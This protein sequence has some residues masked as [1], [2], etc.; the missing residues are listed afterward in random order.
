M[1]TVLAGALCV[2]AVPVV[3]VGTLKQHWTPLL[4]P[5]RDG[6]ALDFSP[7]ELST[8][9]II[10]LM[11]V[12]A[13]RAAM[14]Q[15]G[16]QPALAAELTGAKSQTR[17]AQAS[18]TAV[19][20]PTYTLSMPLTLLSTD[21]KK[22][23]DALEGRSKSLATS[24]GT[25]DLKI[26]AASILANP[27]HLSLFLSAVS[28]PAFL[29]LLA[30]RDCPVQPLGSVNVR[31]RFELLDQARA[32]QIIDGVGNS[33]SDGF[34]T[35][36]Q[37]RFQPTTR[38]AKR[39]IEIDIVVSIVS[40]DNCDTPVPHEIF[41]QTFTVLEFVKWPEHVVTSLIPSVRAS[42]QP[43][44]SMGAIKKVENDSTRQDALSSKIEMMSNDPGLWAA[45]CLDYNPIH[46]L[47]A[48][49]RAAGFT[50]RLAHGNHVAA[51][52]IRTIEA[53]VAVW[54]P[55]QLSSLDRFVM[56]V[57]FKGPVAV[58]SSLDLM[59]ENLQA[60]FKE[61]ATGPAR[62][63]LLHRNRLCVEIVLGSD[64]VS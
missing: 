57:A 22:Y 42:D 1:W 45:L 53:S 19:H 31:N 32:Q 23:L 13:L 20:L 11:A 43:A 18:A 28:E 64:N 17:P 24:P 63:E 34:Q 26:R 3:V 50:G 47:R 49:A 5:G 40:S 12:I 56:A 15:L 14:I 48:A 33:A 61:A 8:L 30:R 36:I 51:R 59:A 21:I 44:D 54:T 2:V 58:P 55:A 25:N 41:R 6:S 46:H 27:A 10:L 35:T 16:L 9:D 4:H 38:L 7:N 62:I 60:A 52:A 37:A 39:G 29:I